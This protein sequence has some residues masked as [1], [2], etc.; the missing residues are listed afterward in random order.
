MK[1]YVKPELFYEHYELSQHIADCAWEWTTLMNEDTCVAVPDPAK[2]P[3][4]FEGFEYKLFTSD[5]ICTLLKSQWSDYCYQSG[6][7]FS[8]LF[9]S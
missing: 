4:S 1:K 3:I 2:N 9:R 6:D 8:N 7:E 5:I